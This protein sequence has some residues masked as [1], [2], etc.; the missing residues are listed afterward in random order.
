MITTSETTHGERHTSL[1]LRLRAAMTLPAATIKSPR[2]SHRP[3]LS[4]STEGAVINALAST[5]REA[6]V[7]TD[8][9][10]RRG[11]TEPAYGASTT[12]ATVRGDAA[13]A[14][15]PQRPRWLREAI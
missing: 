5:R 3:S 9:P 10:L 4:R 12:V 15:A 2:A 13:R 6:T 8:A 11:L 14:R 1:D 7:A